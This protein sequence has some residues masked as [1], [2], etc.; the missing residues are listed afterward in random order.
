[1]WLFEYRD[2]TA[3]PGE[4]ITAVLKTFPSRFSANPSIRY[5]RNSFASARTLF[6]SGPSNG[7]AASAAYRS[8][9]NPGVRC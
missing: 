7:S 1:M 8:C 4:N 2:A 5:T 9:V 6:N 3:P